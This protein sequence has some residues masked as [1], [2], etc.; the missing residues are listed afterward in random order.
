MLSLRSA[1]FAGTIDQTGCWR[2]QGRTPASLRLAVWVNAFHRL[3][4]IDGSRL[5]ASVTASLPPSI[6]LR[7]VSTASS[8]PDIWRECSSL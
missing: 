6:S 3:S 1:K 2:E 7:I 5:V 8:E 4:C